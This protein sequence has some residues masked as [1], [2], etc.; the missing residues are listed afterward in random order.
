LATGTPYAEGS[1]A[2]AALGVD[3]EGFIVYAEG[4]SPGALGAA[5]QAAGVSRALAL[6][7]ERLQLAAASPDAGTAESPDAGNAGAEDS[8]TFVEQ[9][10]APAEVLFPHVKPMPY[11][12][13]GYLQDQRVRYFPTSHQARFP[14][15]SAAR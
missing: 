4:Q 13:W 5:L 7:T 11:N 14:M 12:R 15:P 3:A 10:Q 9:T 2:L 6:E 1:Q 8:L